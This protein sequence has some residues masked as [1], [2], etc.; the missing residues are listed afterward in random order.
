MQMMD[1]SPPLNVSHRGQCCSPPPDNKPD[2][3]LHRGMA[4]HRQLI[5]AEG[6]SRD[7]CRVYSSVDQPDQ[8]HYPSSKSL[9]ETREA[10]RRMNLFLFL[11]LRG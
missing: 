8:H 7:D 6:E 9:V 4:R 2:R 3:S 11:V 1:G 5:G 10:D